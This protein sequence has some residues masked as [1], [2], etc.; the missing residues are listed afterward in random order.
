MQRNRF[1]IPFVCVLAQGIIML[2]SPQMVDQ[3]LYL[4]FKDGNSVVSATSYMPVII[5]QYPEWKF[6]E[7]MIGGGPPK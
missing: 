7:D 1:S 6:N 3:G 2:I 5:D 4:S